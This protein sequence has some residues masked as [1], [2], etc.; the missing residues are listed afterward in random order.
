MPV[1]WCPL[2]R[3]GCGET[4]PLMDGWTPVTSERAWRRG[5]HCMSLPGTVQ[6][7]LLALPRRKITYC[8]K[9]ISF[10]RTRQG[11]RELKDAMACSSPTLGQGCLRLPCDTLSDVSGSPAGSRLSC[12]Q[13]HFCRIAHRKLYRHRQTQQKSV[14]ILLA[15][16]ST[17]PFPLK[18][19]CLD[20]S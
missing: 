7:A 12:H 3:R 18:P 11:P 20:S 19:G 1:L 4:T 10:Q 13:G 15:L 9:L 2:W 5:C 8:D 16:L 6:T 14:F 17:L